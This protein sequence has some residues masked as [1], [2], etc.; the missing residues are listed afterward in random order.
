[1]SLIV[2]MLRQQAVYWPL[3]RL[4]ATGAAVCGEPVQI[5]V[6]WEGGF[7]QVLNAQG[8]LS[9]AKAKIYVDRDVT[10]GGF[11][12]LGVLQDT[13][14]NLN[15]ALVPGAERVIAFNSLPNMKATLFL[16][17]AFL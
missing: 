14:Y 16:R 12:R 5:K 15:P 7:Q 8:E 2:K 6:R 3:L 11:L 9:M 17:M 10:V 13:D 4:D 1:M